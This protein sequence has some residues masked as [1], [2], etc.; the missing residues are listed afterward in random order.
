M[1]PHA[2]LSLN[3][4]CLGLTLCGRGRCFL[5]SLCTVVVVVVLSSNCGGRLF[6][7]EKEVS[8]S[9]LRFYL[10]GENKCEIGYFISWYNKTGLKPSI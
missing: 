5:S 6:L 8:E 3:N 4:E 1:R 9:G 2:P 7:L 10:C